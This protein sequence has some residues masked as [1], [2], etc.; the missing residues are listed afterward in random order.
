MRKVKR[1]P[2]VVLQRWGQIT[3]QRFKKKS[4][5]IGRYKVIGSNTERW[6]LE[7]QQH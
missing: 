7:M 4:I 6:K 2:G 1:Q 3:T 5:I